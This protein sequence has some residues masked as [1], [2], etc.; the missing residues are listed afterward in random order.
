[1]KRI[2]AY[3][4]FIFSL[5]KKI[6][7]ILLLFISFQAIAQDDSYTLI[8]AKTIFDG[9]QFHTNKAVL[10]K[11]NKIIAFD[12]VANIKIPKG[13]KTIN[14]PN[15]TLMPGMIEGHSHLLLHPY[16]ET[17]WNDQVLKE[18]Y[19]ERAIRGANHAKKTLMAGFTT[20]RDLGSE[21]ASY[22][23]V[24]LKETIE[25]NVIIGPR[26]IVA[27]KAIV[28]TG[29]YGPKGFAEHV[30]VPLGAETA[31]GIDDL[32]RVVRDQIGH[33][34]DV[35]KV[36][37]DYRWSPDNK[38]APTFTLKELKLIVEV[39]ES[40]GR[41]VVAH[42]A[43]EEGMRRAILAGVSTIEH[44]DGGT[45]EIFEL[46]KKHNVALCPT[47]AAGDAIAQYQGWKKGIDPAP[48]RITKKKKS[49]KLIL[50]TGVTIVAGGDVGVF[51]HG[52]NVRELEMMVQYGMNPLSVLQSVTSVNA[53][54]F[55]YENSIGQIKIGL[56]ADLVVVDGNPIKNISNLRRINMV[57]KDGTIFKQ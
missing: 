39:A 37:A 31:D 17:S 18:S 11:G 25:K 3:F 13:T 7:L 43:S 16:N 36:Y 22:V 57:I 19:A 6:I 38:A 2:N 54:A 26:M 8:K 55:G 44:G 35:I 28:T 15:G 14:Y 5:F 29:S 34:A 45:K 49:F 48:T 33:G 41:K 50:E 4:L 46:M 27:G 30:T 10:I 23:D 12:K 42:A 52:D 20:I 56:L 51:P 32:T 47:L 53:K 21:G 24:G 40:S 9:V 1:M